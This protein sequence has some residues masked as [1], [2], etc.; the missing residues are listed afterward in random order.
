[1]A[2]VGGK[3]YVS[4][5]T[6]GFYDI[7]GTRDEIIPR[8]K[9]SVHQYTNPYVLLDIAEFIEDRALEGE[10]LAS[11]DRLRADIDP[12]SDPP[13]G[14]TPSRKRAIGHNAPG[15]LQKRYVPAQSTATQAVY[16]RGAAMQMP[17]QAWV[18]V[19]VIALF[20]AGLFVMAMVGLPTKPGTPGSAFPPT[21]NGQ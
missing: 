5:F 21:I 1:V 19:A 17:T 3:E 20:T 13:I 10:A 4:F 9:K 16:A 6:N 2:H 18:L 7:I 8:L 15:S 11:I 14:N 12:L